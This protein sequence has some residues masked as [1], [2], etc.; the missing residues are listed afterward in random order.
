VLSAAGIEPTIVQVRDYGPSSGEAAAELLFGLPDPPTAV[1][2]FSDVTAYGV[3]RAASRRGVSVPG[4]LS[5]V[6]FDDVPLASRMTPPLTTIRQDGA[7]KGR[8]AAAA[9]VAATARDRTGSDEVLEQRILPVE[10]VIRAS[11]SAR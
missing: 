3:V 10:L 11:T 7:A 8:A 4:A 1:L 6:G 9:L 5:V 2:C